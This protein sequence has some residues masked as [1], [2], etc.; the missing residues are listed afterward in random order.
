MAIELKLFKSDTGTSW[1]FR[2]V[3][4]A[5]FNQPLVV[6]KVNPD[7]LAENAGMMVGDVIVR[8]N[9]DSTTG[10]THVQTHDLLHQAGCQLSLGIRRG[11]FDDI[12][13][14]N[15]DEDNSEIESILDNLNIAYKSDSKKD[16]NTGSLSKHLENLAGQEQIAITTESKL[17]GE[18]NNKPKRWSTFLV[19]PKNPKPAPKKVEEERKIIGEPYRV[20]IIKQ[21]RRDPNDV[22]NHKKSVRFEPNV[23]EVE[24][25]QEE[26]V[27]DQLRSTVELDTDGE[28]GEK[29]MEVDLKVSVEEETTVEICELDDESERNSDII[30]NDSL[31]CDVIKNNKEV[32]IKKPKPILKPSPL[33]I[34]IDPVI[35]E[36]SLSLED[37]LAAVQKQLLALSNLPS[38]IQVTLEAVTQQLNKI[39]S[40][41]THRIEVNHIEEDNYEDNVSENDVEEEIQDMLEKIEE[42]PENVSTSENAEEDI[43]E[44]EADENHNIEDL[45]EDNGVVEKYDD[46]RDVEEET[47]KIVDPYEGLTEEERETKI[48]EEELMAKKQKEEEE[49]RSQMDWTQRP[50]ILP[51]GRKWSDPEDATPKFK[52]PK[53][54]DEKICKTI[55]DYS[56]VIMGK[57]S[58][59]GIGCGRGAIRASQFTVPG[60][61][62]ALWCQVKQLM[63][64][65][66]FLKYQ[67][68]PKNLDYLQKSE[69]YRLIH[70]MEPPVRG[71]GARA[72]KILSERDYYG[73][74]GAP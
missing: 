48:R 57:T 12:P 60:N 56:E 50:I 10:L 42:S 55:E 24:L 53:M 35:C 63:S 27:T 72:E 43:T 61:P 25:Q 47:N 73:G 20:K 6:V 26:S 68:P 34:H 21:A 13:I 3:G 29:E 8:I 44:A 17:V 71:V 49:R 70:G 45:E 30:E 51:G 52:T 33:D 7:S 37:Q 11:L 74:K 18:R 16:L 69:V 19:K 36:S 15:E 39:V 38:A 2:L 31:E 65:I 4:G 41:K 28:V 32:T 9:D 67:P 54:S 14:I 66:N 5:E 59:I 64:C 62:I 22:L 46:E 58:I 23:P 40:E 1:G